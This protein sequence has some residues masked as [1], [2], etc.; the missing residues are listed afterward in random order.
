MLHCTRAVQ[1]TVVSLLI[2][3]RV[4]DYE[5]PLS[6]AAPPERKE[7]NQARILV[8]LLGWPF[9]EAAYATGCQ[10]RVEVN[11]NDDARLALT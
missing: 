4:P 5:R 3:T 8:A 2:S 9:G 7:K 10:A 11:N 1:Q 6:A